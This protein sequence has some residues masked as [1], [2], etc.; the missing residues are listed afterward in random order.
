M[1]EVLPGRT[2]CPAGRSR[3]APHYQDRLPRPGSTAPRGTVTFCRPPRQR[4]SSRSNAA[5]TTPMPQPGARRAT[6]SE[7]GHRDISIEPA[8][9]PVVVRLDQRPRRRPCRRTTQPW[10][11]PGDQLRPLIGR[12]RLATGLDAPPPPD[13]CG[14]F[15]G[16]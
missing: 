12:Q 2:T 6:R 7:R 11:P 4:N 16:R 5:S 1:P 15:C 9:N 14:W 8:L 13:I 10:K 3:T